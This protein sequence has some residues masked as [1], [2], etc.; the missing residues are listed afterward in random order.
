[1]GTMSQAI[2]R[3]W[4]QEAQGAHLHARQPIG[5]RLHYLCPCHPLDLCSYLFG[6]VD[7]L[8][9]DDMQYQLLKCICSS[10]VKRTCLDSSA[11]RIPVKRSQHLPAHET[12]HLQ[13][14][15]CTP[16]LVGAYLEVT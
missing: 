2:S 7:Y 6:I 4:E 1:M 10:H 12:F 16:S 13:F 9:L 14:K 15:L 8:P 11:L 3:W 5:R